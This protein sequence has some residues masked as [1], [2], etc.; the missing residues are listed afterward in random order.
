VSLT[1]FRIEATSSPSRVENIERTLDMSGV[2]SVSVSLEE[3]YVQ[4]EHDERLP[5]DHLLAALRSAG[6]HATLRY[7]VK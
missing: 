5:I 7:W 3:R 2:E 4:I 6:Y 1:V